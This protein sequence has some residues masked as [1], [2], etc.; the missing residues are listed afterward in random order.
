MSKL[1]H[2]IEVK[3]EHR[4]LYRVVLLNGVIG[5][6]A[7]SKADAWRHFKYANKL[8]KLSKLSGN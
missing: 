5:P 8:N 6:W 3:T 2:K 7:C 4:R 1:R